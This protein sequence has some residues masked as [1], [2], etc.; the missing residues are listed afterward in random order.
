MQEGVE[1]VNIKLNQVPSNPYLLWQFL[2]KVIKVGIEF[3]HNFHINAS[4]SKISE[5]LVPIPPLNL[6]FEFI[7]FSNIQF[8]IP[9]WKDL[10][11]KHIICI[12][13]PGILRYKSRSIIPSLGH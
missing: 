6:S 8:H 2:V 4:I 10:P 9:F 5:L 12:L 3:L 1:G 11:T 13:V 7:K